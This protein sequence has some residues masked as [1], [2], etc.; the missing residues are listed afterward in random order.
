MADI[1]CP[2][3]RAT[4]ERAGFEVLGFD[5]DDSVEARAVAKLLE[6]DQGEGAMKL[7]DLFARY[8]LL[9]RR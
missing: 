4:L 3:D 1:A 7:E 8:T 9:R 5:V 2:F 6:W